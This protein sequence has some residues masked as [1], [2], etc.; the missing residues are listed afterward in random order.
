MTRLYILGELITT[1][2]NHDVGNTDGNDCLRFLRPEDAANIKSIQT[3]HRTPMSPI[4]AFYD[5]SVGEIYNFWL[6]HIRPP[7][8]VVSSGWT[9]FTF[10]M[11]DA[12]STK[13]RKCTLCCDAPDI[14]ETGDEV[15]LKSVRMPFAEAA[16][17]MLS[18]EMM[19]MA[20]SEW[21]KETAF[22]VIPPVW[23]DTMDTP[24]GELWGKIATPEYV[25]AAK[26][27]ALLQV[28]AGGVE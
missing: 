5:W 22:S 27:R 11:L 3:A 20:P 10:L 2:R 15:V 7:M 4:A 1:V 19:S 17:R 21:N 25:K 28:E 24:L 16:V 23:V 9:S 6:A 8:D 18:F 13:D 12:N 14:G 26:R